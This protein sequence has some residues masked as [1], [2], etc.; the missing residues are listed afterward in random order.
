MPGVF[1]T[2]FRKAFD[3]LSW[4]FLFECLRKF[5]F[6]NDFLQMGQYPVHKCLKAV[7]M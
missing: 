3:C 7:S 1:L 2:D 4:D 6:K 5:G